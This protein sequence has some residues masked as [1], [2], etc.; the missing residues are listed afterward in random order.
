M[1]HHVNL[2]YNQDWKTDYLCYFNI[3][4]ELNCAIQEYKNIF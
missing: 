4:K 2:I 3:I 1:Y